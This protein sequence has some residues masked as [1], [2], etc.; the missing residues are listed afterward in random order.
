MAVATSAVAECNDSEADDDD[1]SNGSRSAYHDDT[2][3]GASDNTS[4]E[5]KGWFVKQSKCPYH[6]DLTNLLGHNC[7]GTRI[8]PV[9]VL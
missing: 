4:E 1:D 3:N 2:D 5:K 6:L 8:V 9:Y 7:N